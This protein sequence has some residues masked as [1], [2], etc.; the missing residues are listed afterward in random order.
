[1]LSRSADH[2]S[3][4]PTIAKLYMSHI[5]RQDPK[6]PK[7]HRCYKWHLLLPFVENCL[8]ALGMLKMMQ[9]TT[10]VGAKAIMLEVKHQNLHCLSRFFYWYGL[11]YTR[12]CRS[13]NVCQ[14][15]HMGG[16]I[17]THIPVCVYTQ[18]NAKTMGDNLTKIV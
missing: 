9:A 15:K 4:Q 14:K 18:F 3:N 12:A 11:C 2:D 8:L 17:S 7:G 6:L 10:C 13:K 16:N 5:N 1:M